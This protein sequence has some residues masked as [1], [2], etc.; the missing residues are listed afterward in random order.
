MIPTTHSSAPDDEG[1]DDQAQRPP[2]KEAENHERDPR[3]L[4]ELIKLCCDG[5]G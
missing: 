3:W 1:E 4:S 5:H 2:G